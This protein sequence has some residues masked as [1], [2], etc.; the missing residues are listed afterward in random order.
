MIESFRQGGD[1]HSRSAALMF[2]HVMDAALRPGGDD[3]NLDLLY[4]KENFFIDK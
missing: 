1:F 3:D 4:I 2:P